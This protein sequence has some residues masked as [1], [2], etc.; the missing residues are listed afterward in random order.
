MWNCQEDRHRDHWDRMKS[1]EIPH[2][3]Q[4]VQKYFGRGRTAFNQWWR[5]TCTPTAKEPN[6][7]PDTMTHIKI[8]SKCITG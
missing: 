3:V 6:P 7:N 2:K 4:E 8:N 5:S 1:P